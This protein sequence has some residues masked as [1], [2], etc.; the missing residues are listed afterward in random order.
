MTYE[1]EYGVDEASDLLES[2]ADGNASAP[3]FDGSYMI[4]DEESGAFYLVFGKRFKELGEK[5]SGLVKQSVVAIRD[6]LSSVKEARVLGRE[7]FF[8][9]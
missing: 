8:Y 6:G 9:R 2:S 4:L 5:A 1:P 3:G 7:A